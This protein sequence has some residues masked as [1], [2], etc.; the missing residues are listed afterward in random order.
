MAT[1]A[2]LEM[3][4]PTYLKKRERLDPFIQQREREKF[5]GTKIRPTNLA[6]E[7]SGESYNDR[8]KDEIGH[9]VL[10]TSQ[11]FTQGT[12]KKV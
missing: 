3:D 9:Q 8:E 7:K 12:N 10:D 11:N 1:P 5:E 6:R 4:T 2:Y